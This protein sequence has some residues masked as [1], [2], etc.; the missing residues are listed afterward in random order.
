MSKFRPEDG[1][2]LAF[3]VGY[4]G[5]AFP[6]EQGRVHRYKTSSKHL[7]PPLSSVSGG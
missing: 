2:L 3:R 1:R 4:S 7:I 5:T 6:K